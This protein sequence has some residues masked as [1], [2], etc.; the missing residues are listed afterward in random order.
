MV[1]IYEFVNMNKPI[2]SVTEDTMDEYILCLRE[3][4]E[5]NDITI[6]FYLRS[7]RAVLYLHSNIQDLIGKNRVEN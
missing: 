2:A 7:V 3:N 4:T 5:A 1:H 6:N